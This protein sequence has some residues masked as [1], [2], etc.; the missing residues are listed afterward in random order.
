MADTERDRLVASLN[1][2]AIAS[3]VT[4]ALFAVPILLSLLSAAFIFVMPIYSYLIAITIGMLGVIG[5]ALFVV[6][7]VL[8][9][10]WIY[11]AHDNLARFGLQG[12]KY[13][14][15]WAAGSFLVPFVNLVV[16][17]RAMRE[18]WNR[19]HGEDEWQAEAGVS[20]VSSWWAC[21]IGG[22]L[23]QFIQ[24]FVLA[25]NLLTNLKFLT[26]P[27]VSA[28]LALLGQALILGSAVF[29]FRIIGSITRAQRTDAGVGMAF[30]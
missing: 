2:L 23:L 9:M 27:L 30:A 12:L 18:L 21:L 22:S 26:P 4:I 15:G 19:S 14:P 1:S 10:I 28:T 11:R 20:D 3:R 13:S 17:F 25:V 5:L 6:A 16:P 8:V 7:G 24:Y 29:L